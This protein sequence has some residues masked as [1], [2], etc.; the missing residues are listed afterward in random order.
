MPNHCDGP[1]RNTNVHD[2][3]S[4]WRG[5]RRRC[6]HV[7][8]LRTAAPGEPAG[9]AVATSVVGED[10]EPTTC[11]A[12]CEATNAPVI[13]TCTEAMGEHDDGEGVR[14]PVPASVEEHAVGGPEGQLL[15][16]RDRGAAE[17]EP[18]TTEPHRVALAFSHPA[19]V[20]RGGV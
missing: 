17:L 13:P 1:H 14:A 2:G 19:L 18:L 7:E 12:L 5:R 8:V 11:Q 16:V 20:H 3:Q 9:L 6:G 15:E 4:S 10:V